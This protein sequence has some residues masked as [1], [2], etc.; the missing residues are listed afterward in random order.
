MMKTPE[1]MMDAEDRVLNQTAGSRAQ[2][3]FVAEAFCRLPVTLLTSYQH[4]YGGHSQ[5]CQYCWQRQYLHGQR[6]FRE[7]STAQGSTGCCAR[8]VP[9]HT[10]LSCLADGMNAEL[11]MLCLSAVAS[12]LAVLRIGTGPFWPE[13]MIRA[14]GSGLQGAGPQPG[15]SD[16]LD[17]DA[18]L[19]DLL[20]ISRRRRAGVGRAL[21]L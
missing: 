4:R 1:Q 12:K 14:P 19:R 20:C 17:N 8:R 9:G 13:L 5:Q 11:S 10:C 16:R 15:R 18:T 21:G 7:L 2:L 6:R 3:Q